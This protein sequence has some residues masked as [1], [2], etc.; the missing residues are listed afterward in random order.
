[1]VDQ[2]ESRE[3]WVYSA[4]GSFHR[5]VHVCPDELIDAPNWVDIWNA[6]EKNG[7]KWELTERE[8]EVNWHTSLFNV[9]F[10]PFCGLN[11]KA[12]DEV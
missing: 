8:D 11:L 7:S 1:M 2:K 6:T 9:T 10:C 5:R 4:G 12:A 3:R